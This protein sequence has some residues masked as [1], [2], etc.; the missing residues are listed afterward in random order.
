MK[1]LLPDNIG[2]LQHLQASGSHSAIAPLATG[3]RPRLRE[4]NSLLSWALCFTSYVAILVESHPGLVRSHL[5]YFMLIIAEA[6]RIGGDGWQSYDAIF[7]Q[8]AA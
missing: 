7:R 5:A 6:R 2:L 4:A 1:E 3:S 8:N